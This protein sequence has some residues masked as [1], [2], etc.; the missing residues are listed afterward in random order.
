MKLGSIK[1]YILHETKLEDVSLKI[2]KTDNPDFLVLQADRGN[3]TI[4]RTKISNKEEGLSIIALHGGDEFR[5]FDSDKEQSQEGEGGGGLLSHYPEKRKKKRW[6][7]KRNKKKDGS[8]VGNA[9]GREEGDDY[10]SLTNW[11]PDGK[12]PRDDG[13]DANMDEL[14]RPGKGQ[15]TEE[16]GGDIKPLGEDSIEV[17]KK[18]Q[19][20]NVNYDAGYGETD[21][22][23]IDDISR[24][25]NHYNEKAQKLKNRKEKQKSLQDSYTIRRPDGKVIEKVPYNKAVELSRKYPN[26]IIIKK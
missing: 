25:R 1:S 24:M 19:E 10:Y 23:M 6:N 16:I 15:N 8:D 5:Q 7:K 9:G 2:M 12:V 3:K 17:S 4:A 26:S 20:Y 21:N 13:A 14:E 11:G 22:P 18:P